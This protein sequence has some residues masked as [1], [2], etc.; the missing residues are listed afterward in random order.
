SA[1]L[2]PDA[3]VGAPP[4]HYN[5]EGQNWGLPPMRPSALRAAAYEPF[6]ALL[7]ANMRHAGALRIDHAMALTRLFWIPAGR[8][9]SAGSY[10]GYPFADLAAITALESQRQRC[11]VIGEDLGS[12]PEGFRERLG[13]L[14]ILSYRVLWFERVPGGG[15]RPPDDYPRQ[16]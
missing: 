15:F 9:G 10:V 16:A 11:L 3:N 1:L 14:G 4:D 12:V 6:V 8:P 13:A 2:A 7:R 5:H